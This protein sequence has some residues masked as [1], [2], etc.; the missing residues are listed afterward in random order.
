KFKNGGLKFQIPYLMTFRNNTNSAGSVGIQ[1]Q[2][3]KGYGHAI[4]RIMHTVFNTTENSNTAFDCSNL[5]GS[6]LQSYGTYINSRKLQDQDLSGLLPGYT[7]PATPG[8]TLCGMDDWLWNKKYFSNSSAMNALQYQLT[9][10]HID[11]FAEPN[12][13]ASAPQEN[14]NDGLPIDAPIIWTLNGVTNTALNHYTF[15]TF[16]RNLTI[17]P[18]GNIVTIY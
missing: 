17:E 10:C 7:A 3:N 9:W 6:K 11:S 16:L 4:K 5:S 2:M 8:G 1:I 14:I 12:D 15:V 13:G 18:I